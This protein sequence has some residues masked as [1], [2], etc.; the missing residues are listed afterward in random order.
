MNTNICVCIQSM[1]NTYMYICMCV[2]T[3]TYAY[4]YIYLQK[5]EQKGT[6]TSVVERRGDLEKKVSG[7][8]ER[9]SWKPEVQSSRSSLWRSLPRGPWVSR[10]AFLGFNFLFY[11]TR[12]WDQDALWSH[13]QSYTFYLRAWVQIPT[14]TPYV[15]LGRWPLW[16]SVSST[17][18]L[19]DCDIQV[20][21][22]ALSPWSYILILCFKCFWL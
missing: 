20:P 6:Q 3:H 8:V 9:S 5:Y 16:T 4:T 21:S 14:L 1:Y 17:V 15:T 13:F 10:S 7:S 19:E 2:Y 12:R 22:S 18:K 11:K